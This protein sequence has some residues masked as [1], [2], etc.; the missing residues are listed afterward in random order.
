M[1]VRLLGLEDQAKAQKPDA[2]LHFK[3]AELIGKKYPWAKGYILAAL[4]N[5]LFDASEQ[6]VQPEKLSKPRMDCGVARQ[7]AR[8]AIRGIA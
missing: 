4:E 6:A 5:G 2:K 3:D 8:A 1:A 7:V